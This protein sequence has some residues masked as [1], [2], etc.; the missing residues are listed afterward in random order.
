M[1]HKMAEVKVDSMA[2]RKAF[3][4]AVLMAFLRGV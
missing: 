2:A 4:K 1:V 3:W